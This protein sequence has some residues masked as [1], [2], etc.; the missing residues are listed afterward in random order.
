[1]APTEVTDTAGAFSASLDGDTDGHARIVLHGELDMA[2]T[3]TFAAKLAEAYKDTPAELVIDLT[4][5]NYCDSSGIR[6]FLRAAQLC[7]NNGTE[8]RLIGASRTV[9]RVFDITGLTEAFSFEP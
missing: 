4:H 6:E 7:A 3:P 1:V 8:L 2:T 9:R 5:V